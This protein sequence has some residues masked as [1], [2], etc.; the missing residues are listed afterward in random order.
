MISRLIGS[1]WTAAKPAATEAAQQATRAA[2]ETAEAGAKNLGVKETLKATGSYFYRAA[3]SIIKGIKNLILHPIESL[4]TAFQ[5]CKDACT[6]L[7]A[8]IK[9]LFGKG[10]AQGAETAAKEAAGGASAGATSKAASETVEGVVNGQAAKAAKPSATS[11]VAKGVGDDVER[12]GVPIS[13]AKDQRPLTPAEIALLNKAEA[14]AAGQANASTNAVVPHDALGH[15][16]TAKPIPLPGPKADAAVT[17]APS[18][19]S[20]GELGHPPSAAPISKAVTGP[21]IKANITST[22]GADPALKRRRS[23]LTAGISKPDSSLTKATGPNKGPA[24]KVNRRKQKQHASHGVNAT[25]ARWSGTQ[26]SLN[27]QHRGGT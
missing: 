14:G 13:V 16:P 11:A 6:S 19:I 15:P 18:T 22:G 10:G 3:K 25:Q 24:G 8:K 17:K 12:V 27:Q 20:S 5:F 26:G 21:E 23:I 1:I 7:I 4:K 2:G 9:G